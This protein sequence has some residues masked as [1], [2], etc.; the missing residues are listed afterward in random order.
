MSQ[1]LS[2][3]EGDMDCSILLA[4]ILNKQGNASSAIELLQTAVLTMLREQHRSE[5]P[6]LLMHHDKIRYGFQCSHGM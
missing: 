2:R 1:V 5:Q 4:N 3:Y 6:S